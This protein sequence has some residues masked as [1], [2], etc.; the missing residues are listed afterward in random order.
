[1][2]ESTRVTAEKFIR[3]YKKSNGIKFPKETIEDFIEN[4]K[5]TPEQLI[6]GAE[7]LENTDWNEFFNWDDDK[8]GIFD[9]F[10]TE[11]IEN[12]RDFQASVVIVEFLASKIETDKILEE[13]FWKFVEERG[14]GYLFK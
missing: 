9:T 14:Y 4:M 2:V 1:M 3:S 5:A 12:S 10:K 8:D 7:I 13:E 6:T 11:R